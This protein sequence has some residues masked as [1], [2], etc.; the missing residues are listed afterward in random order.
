VDLTVWILELTLWHAINYQVTVTVTEIC[1]ALMECPHYHP[2][3]LDCFECPM[4]D[5]A[6]GMKGEGTGFCV[7]GSCLNKLSV[8]VESDDYG[9]HLSGQDIV[10]LILSKYEL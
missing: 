9:M 4:L 10:E 8:T 2:L 7:P 5:E 3:K 1:K 6:M